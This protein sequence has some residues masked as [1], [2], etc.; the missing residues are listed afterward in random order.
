MAPNSKRKLSTLDFEK[1]IELLKCVDNG[2]KKSEVAKKFGIPP[3]TLSTILKNRA[4][5][6]G[7]TSTHTPNAKRQRLAEYPD[8]EECLFRWFTQKQNRQIP[9]SGPVLQEQALTFAKSMGIDSFTASGGWL[10][11]FKKRYDITFKKICGESA[12]VS[13]VTCEKWKEELPSVLQNYAPSDIFNCDETGLFFKCLP[14]ST[15]C[16]RTEKCFGGKRSKERITVLLGCNSTGTEKLPTLLI[17]KSKKPRCF[18]GIKSFPVLYEANSRAWMTT[19][20][21]H[22]WLIRIDTMMS[23]KNRKILLLMDNCPSHINLP[24]L[25]AV[26]IKFFPPNATS[27]LQPLDCGT[28]QNFKTFCRSDLMRNILDGIEKGALFQINILVA[29]RMVDKAW[30]KVSEVTIAD[31]FKK[32]GFPAVS[33]LQPEEELPSID[34]GDWDRVVSHLDITGPDVISFQDFVSFDDNVAVSGTLTDDEI[35]QEVTG[36][37]ESTTDDDP[38]ETEPEPAPTGQEVRSALNILRRFTE[39]SPQTA[40]AEFN[41]LHTLEMLFEHSVHAGLNQSTLDSFLNK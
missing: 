27:K 10:D 37:E 32:A 30:R 13:D 22:G 6:E 4:K 18:S 28:I 40:A 33:N 2:E 20:L 3:N 8:L 29:M 23:K 5:I 7:S 41:S 35:V 39:F 12:S 1:K 9:I 26:E 11:K 16:L 25:S 19:E 24:S 21:F 31:C 17:G 38:N 14:D 36:T 34:M 15:L